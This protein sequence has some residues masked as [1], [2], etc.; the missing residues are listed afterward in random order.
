MRAEGSQNGDGGVMASHN[1]PIP[2]AAGYD[3]AEIFLCSR[4]HGDPKETDF[5]RV[6]SSRPE[7]G[8]GEHILDEAFVQRSERSLG[9]RI[10]GRPGQ[11]VLYHLVQEM[12]TGSHLIDVVMGVYDLQ[13]GRLIAEKHEGDACKAAHRLEDE[14]G[15]RLF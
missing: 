11:R 5:V 1:I 3:R 9:D 12:T 7:P 13:T 2:P 15:L 4:L 10:H 6:M 8:V 14:E